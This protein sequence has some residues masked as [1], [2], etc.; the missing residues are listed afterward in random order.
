VLLTSESD[1][2]L[3]S[4]SFREEEK[5]T[6]D[7]LGYEPRFATGHYRSLFAIESITAQLNKDETQLLQISPVFS[8]HNIMPIVGTS[9]F[10]RGYST[11]R[12]NYQS[13][14]ALVLR[15]PHRPQ[16]WQHRKG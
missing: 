16:K 7:L 13:Y 8:N 2:D 1:W 14:G 12:M 4:D 11:T 9:S 5:K 10:N 3:H 6:V 15:L